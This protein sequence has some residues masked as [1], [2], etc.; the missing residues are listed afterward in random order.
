MCYGGE[1]HHI[2]LKEYVGNQSFIPKVMNFKYAV[3]TAKKRCN[4]VNNQSLGHAQK[5]GFFRLVAGT[6]ATYCPSQF[7]CRKNPFV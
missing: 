2:T 6:P 7:F 5:S 4:L 1:I 3:L